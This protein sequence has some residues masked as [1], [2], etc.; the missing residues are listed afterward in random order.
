MTQLFPKARSSTCTPGSPT[1]W[2]RPGRRPAGRRGD[3]GP[4]PDAPPVAVPDRGALGVPSHMEAAKGAYVI[5]DY[6]PRARSRDAH[7]RGDLDDRVDLRAARASTAV[8]RPTARSSPRSATKLFMLQPKEYR[9]RV[10]HKAE[11]LDS[12]V[13]SNGSKIGMHP[14]LSS[15]V[16]EQYA[17]TSDW[18]DRWRTGGSVAE[19]KEEAHLDPEHLLEG[20]ERFARD[21][22]LPPGRHQPALIAR[23]PSPTPPRRHH[24]PH[25]HQPHRR[26]RPRQQADR[27][28]LRSPQQRGRGRFG[29]AD[30]GP[31]R[32][33]EPGR[34]PRFRGAHRGAGGLPRGRGRGRDA[35]V[36]ADRRSPASRGSGCATRPGTREHTAWPSASGLRARRRGARRNLEATDRPSGQ[37]PSD[38]RPSTSAWR[39]S[40][41]L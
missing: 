27:G 25:R 5:R 30:E 31:R 15:K 38:E 7:R 10:L 12:T 4:A 24:A 9:D 22:E 11:F 40:S 17:M 28:V 23:D 8:R 33:V 14:W 26:P 6:D 1:R 19:V 2:R 21:R 20:I 32:L 41:P 29:R 36:T 13:I 35:Q 37:T 39:S 16:A 18:D 34:R 3:R